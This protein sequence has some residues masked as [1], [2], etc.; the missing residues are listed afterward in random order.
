MTGLTA[1]SFL[2]IEERLAF[3]DWDPFRGRK[4]RRECSGGPWP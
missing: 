1:S 3:L 4:A 2:V